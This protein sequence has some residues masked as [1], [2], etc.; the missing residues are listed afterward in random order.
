MSESVHSP[1][2]AAQRLLCEADRSERVMSI[3]QT[4]ADLT[5][6]HTAAPTALRITENSGPGTIVLL[7]MRKTS[8][9]SSGSA[10]QHTFSHLSDSS[11]KDRD[12]VLH[13]CENQLDSS[14]MKEK[15]DF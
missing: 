10:F 9:Q 5:C 2:C 12:Q 6:H 14:V 3:R 11:Q 13:K 1:S 4:G 8:H 7:A 15:E